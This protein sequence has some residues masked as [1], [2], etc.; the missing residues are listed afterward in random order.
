MLLSLGFLL[1]CHEN[2][3]IPF[4]AFRPHE[5]EVQFTIGSARIQDA[6]V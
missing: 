1:S 2:Y 5:V 6:V 4:P 3:D